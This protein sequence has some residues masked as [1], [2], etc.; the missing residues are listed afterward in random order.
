LAVAGI[1]VKSAIKARNVF[2]QTVKQVAMVAMDPSH[3]MGEAELF[4]T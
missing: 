3:Q 2:G 4:N 1:Y